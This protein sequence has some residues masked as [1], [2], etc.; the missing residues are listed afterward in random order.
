MRL[1][2]LYPKLS[3]EE[4]ERLAATVGIQPGYLWQI[5]TS[6][7]DKEGRVK[8]ASLDLVAK[9]AAADARLHVQDMVAEFSAADATPSAEAA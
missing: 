5:A 7:R 2:D 3:T 4:K 1:R 8:R 9:L 6:W